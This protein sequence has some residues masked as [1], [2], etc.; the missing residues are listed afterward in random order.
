MEGLWILAELAKIFVNVSRFKYMEN[1]PDGSKF[2]YNLNLI[3]I[4]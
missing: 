4:P 1:I 3:I 2:H